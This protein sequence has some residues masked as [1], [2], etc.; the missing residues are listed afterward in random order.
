MRADVSAPVV[1]LLLAA[2]RARRFDPRGER[3]KLLEPLANEPRHCI[4]QVS[5]TQLRTACDDVLAVVGPDTTPLQQRLHALLQ[6]CGCRLLIN[7]E[8]ARGMGHSLALGVQHIHQTNPSALGVLVAL[9]DMPFVAPATLAAV[10]HTLR[11]GHLTVAPFFQGQRGHPVGFA[12]ALFEPLMALTGDEGARSV[13]TRYPPHRI[14]VTDRGVLRDIDC[15][16]PSTPT[17]IEEHLP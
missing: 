5:A 16:P 8:P 7:P 3:L 13:L 6:A 4:A 10:A 9:A 11:Q 1:G 12:A 2:G 14:D 15:P 17:A